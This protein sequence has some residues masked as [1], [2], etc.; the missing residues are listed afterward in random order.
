MREQTFDDGEAVFREG[1]RSDFAYIIRQG[2][3]EISI[4]RGGD[5][6]RLAILREGEVFG[7][8]G[9]LE[10][11]PRSAN[12]HAVGR[13]VVTALDRPE[14]VRTIFEDREAGLAII[15]ALFE[16]LRAMNHALL[17]GKVDEG[18]LEPPAASPT[19]PAIADGNLRLT[20]APLTDEARRVAGGDLVVAGLPVR[21]GR[22]PM[23]G[24]DAVLAFNEAALADADPA[25]VSLNHLLIAEERGRVVARDRGSRHG[26][27]VNGRRIGGDALRLMQPLQPGRNELTLGPDNSPYRFALDVESNA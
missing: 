9:A 5:R 14:F 15:R 1:D 3:V 4:G 7:E 16:R 20:L 10:E 24:E 11:A 17:E 23:A 2:T 22:H 27:A 18:R 25:I 26:S 19:T 8:M 13:L 21:I 6:V 12:A